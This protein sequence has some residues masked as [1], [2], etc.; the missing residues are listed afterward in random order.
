MASDRRELLRTFALANEFKEGDLLVGG[1]RDESMRSSAREALGALTVGEL[2]RTALVEDGVTEALS[3][4]LDARLVAEISS[5]T[6]GELKAALLGAGGAAWARRHADGLSSEAVAAVVKLMTNEE[7]SAVARKLFNPLPGEGV[8]V[9]SPG[10]FGSRIQPNSPGDDDEEILFSILEGLAYGCG[11]VI[12]GL[13]PAADDVDTIAR[14]EELLRSAVERLELPTRYCVLSDIV[15]QSSAR[16]RSRVDVGFQS[17]AGTSRALGGMVGLDVDG[18]ADLARGFDGLYFETGQGSEVTNGA[19]EGVDML[20]LEARS[21]GVARHIGKHTGAWMIVNDVAGFIGPEV[22]RTGDQL[23]RACLEDTVMAKLHGL[24]MGLDVCSTFHMGIEPEELH[25]LTEQIVERAAP[26]YLMAVAGNA[27]PMLGYLT[28]SFREHPRLREQAGRQVSTPMGKRLSELGVL[29]A[30]GRPRGDA[31]CVAELYAAYMRAGGDTRPGETLRVEGGKKLAALG[32][33]G[34]DLGRGHGADYEPPSEVS[35]RL[36]GIYA[37]ARRALYAALDDA[38]VR[39]ASPRHLRARTEARDREQY[40][41]EPSSGERLRAEDAAR[42]AALY[43]SRRPR[44]QLVLSDGLNADALNENLR[45]VL[46]RLRRGLGEAGLHVGGADVVVS[47]GRVRAG[48]HVGELTGVDA[49]VHLIG[50]RPGTGLNTLS[51]YVTYG[52]DAAG[53]P[54]WSPSLDHSRTT[55]VCGV[56]PKGKRPDAAAD[57]V[58]GC[59]VR[60]FEEGRSGVAR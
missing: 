16:A 44:V 13:N 40:L 48:Y 7:L 32:G 4:S 15:K 41:S 54:L 55:A 19:A 47:N 43:T 6:I 1:T 5:L 45:A 23:L 25:R 3:A 49:V 22:F 31:A 56:H 18:I 60:A 42:V 12:I 9:G 24:T 58:V 52:R 14:L 50:E 28:T 35:A 29:D 11:D 17:L 26:A 38:V 10:H 21:Y 59:V 51:A 8:R 53:R 20:T 46:P 39:E 27:D 36:G 33:R 57:E 2:T 37:H 34:F 30:R